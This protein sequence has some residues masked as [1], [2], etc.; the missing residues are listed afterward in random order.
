MRTCRQECEHES[1]FISFHRWL[2]TLGNTVIWN[3]CVLF[4]VVASLRLRFNRVDSAISVPC[5]IAHLVA[6]WRDGSRA[7][8]VR[9]S[10]HQRTVFMG[11][12]MT[13][14]V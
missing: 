11:S 9:A 2:K 12:V 10:S 5:A 14:G 7:A 8:S 6:S 3:S 1:L 13:R 4:C